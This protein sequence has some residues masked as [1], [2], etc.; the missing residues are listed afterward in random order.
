LPDRKRSRRGSQV[1]VK[2][3]PVAVRRSVHALQNPTSPEPGGVRAGGQGL[4]AYRAVEIPP[5]GW[6]GSHVW[7]RLSGEHTPH[8]T[9][10]SYAGLKQEGWCHK[11]SGRHGTNNAL[12]PVDP[13]G[14]VET[15]LLDFDGLLVG[16][17]LLTITCEGAL[18][19]YLTYICLAG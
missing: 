16:D 2:V 14:R 13:A 17:C 5:T 8:A 10:K 7:S 15:R 1:A 18:I 12:L 3:H 11:F 19:W 6:E 4:V 9:L